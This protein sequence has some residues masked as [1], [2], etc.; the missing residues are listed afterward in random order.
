MIFDAYLIVLRALGI[1]TRLVTCFN[2]AHN[3]KTDF[4]SRRF[5]D[6]DGHV[7]NDNSQ[8]ALW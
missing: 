4:V 5:L 7:N 1:P 2:S 8:D 3:E 6:E